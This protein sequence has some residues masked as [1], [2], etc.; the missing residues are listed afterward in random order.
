MDSLIDS[1]S[2]L[3]K[4]AFWQSWMPKLFTGLLIFLAFWIGSS[5]ITAV[6]RRWAK[7]LDPQRQQVFMLLATCIHVALIVVGVVTV[8]GS[9]GLNV[10]ALITSLGLSGLAL[11]LAVKDTLSNIMGGLMLFIYQPFRV[12]DYIK[13]NEKSLSTSLE[14]TV[15]HLTL[16][17]IYLEGEMGQILVPNASLLT[18]SIVIF[19]TPPAD[20]Q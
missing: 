3:Y 12:G 2:T 1:L 5:L 6:I 16:R 14:G 17:Y 9:L 19:K 8:L 13:V 4:E 20:T 18:N 11:S 7:T 15:T 10:S